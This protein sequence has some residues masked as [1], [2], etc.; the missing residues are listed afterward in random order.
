MGL[1]HPVFVMK[2]RGMRIA[3]H[4][5]C[6]RR[7]AAERERVSGQYGLLGCNRQDCMPEE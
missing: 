5:H 1:E 6:T 2:S 7:R 3:S 4:A